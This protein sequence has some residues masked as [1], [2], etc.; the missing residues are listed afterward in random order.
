MQSNGI[1]IDLNI[2]HGRR[3]PGMIGGHPALLESAPDIFESIEF[4]RADNGGKQFPGIIIG[5]GKAVTFA[6]TRVIFLNSFGQAANGPHDGNTTIAHSYQLS[7]PAWFKT[8]GHKEHVA[9]RVDTLREFGVEGK[10]NRDLLRITSRKIL[11]HLMI[12]LVTNA[13]HHKLDA[14]GQQGLNT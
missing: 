4:K 14:L 13:Q 6:G 12:V 9:S 8:R 1:A 7:Q 5:E 11:E 3:V 10:K 2:A